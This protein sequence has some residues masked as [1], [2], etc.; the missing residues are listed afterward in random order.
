MWLRSQSVVEVRIR[1]GESMRP[2]L[3]STGPRVG[4]LG[5]PAQQLEWSSMPYRIG[6]ARGKRESARSPQNREQ[7]RFRHRRQVLGKTSGE[8]IVVLIL[9]HA[10]RLI[11]DNLL[12]A[13]AS[14]APPPVPGCVGR[15][16][17]DRL[18]ERS[19][20]QR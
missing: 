1:I 12:L 10:V 8:V 9:D 14:S 17:L 3:T 2:V 13:Q 11:S 20:A 5:Y 18:S 16:V 6:V 4:S 15:P 7:P 19:R